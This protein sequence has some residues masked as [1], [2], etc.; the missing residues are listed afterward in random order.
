L[1][2]NTKEKYG[3]DNN[4][5]VKASF[6][7]VFGCDGDNIM[8]AFAGASNFVS[9]YSGNDG[10]TSTFAIAQSGFA[11]AQAVISGKNPDQVTAQANSALLKANRDMK[12]GSTTFVVGSQDGDMVIKHK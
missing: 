4:V 1:E 7:G 2:P 8:N 11:A 6:V 10:G 3:V 5:D 9:T 12:V